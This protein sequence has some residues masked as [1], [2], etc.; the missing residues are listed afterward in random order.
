MPTPISHFAV[1]FAVAAWTQQDAPT[2]RVCVAAAVCGALPDIDVLGSALHVAQTSLFSH[3]ALTHSLTF[4][5]M[6]A[7]AVTRVFFRGDEWGGAQGRTRIGFILALALLSHACL[8]ALST[9]SSGVEFLAPFSQERFRFA[10]TPLGD[11]HWGIG[12]QLAQ[13]AALVLLPAVL[14]AWLGLKIRGRPVASKP[15]AA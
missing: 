12:A 13:E 14:V 7:V 8:D 4:A 6:A 9:Y 1:G 5:L 10:W 11:P 2:R 3:R 15:A